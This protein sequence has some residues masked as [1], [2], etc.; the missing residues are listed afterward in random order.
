M[1]YYRSRREPAELADLAASGV[2][3]RTSNADEKFAVDGDAVWIGSAN[4][5]HGVPNQIDFGLT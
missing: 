2:M 1:S 3:V 5:T 4:A